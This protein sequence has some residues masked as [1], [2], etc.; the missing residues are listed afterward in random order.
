[1]KPILAGLIILGSLAASHTSVFSQEL[2][3]DLRDL[4]GS[5]KATFLQGRETVFEIRRQAFTMTTL[6]PD[7]EPTV[8]KG[9]FILDA[10]KDPKQMTWKD[11]EY[12]GGI[13][14]EVN[15][16][17]YELHGDTWLLMGGLKDR[18]KTFL[19][20]GGTPPTTW[21]FKRQ[22]ENAQS[23]VDP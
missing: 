22:R 8:L 21:I 11:V 9:T 12:A 17:I 3:G 20:G 16:C 19:S 7:T 6:Y 13:I 4:Q 10:S 23:T 18:P 1:M 2:R 5:W 14:H 15:R